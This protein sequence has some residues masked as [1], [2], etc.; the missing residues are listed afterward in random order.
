MCGRFT[1]EYTWQQVH[2]FLDLRWPD[3][4][5]FGPSYNV[6]PTQLSPIV[7]ADD[8]GRGARVARWGLQ[9]LWS[10]KPSSINARA[11]TV[12]TL[13][14]FRAA[15]QARRCVVP[16]SGF[17]EWQRVPV[18]Q[19]CYIRRADRCPM[20]LAGLW[21]PSNG[22]APPTFAIITTT[23]NQFMEAM[24][25]RMPAVLEP[26]CVERWLAE[27]AADL[28]R[29]A[30]EHILTAHRVSPQVNRPANDFYGLSEKFG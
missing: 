27:P 26:E 21:E 22:E 18:K 29:P 15:F 3:A 9:P 23:P 7:L 2:D 12:A 5:A 13:P 11:E 14:M 24:H 17:H 4:L 30:G 28:L 8:R 20:L 25:D 19:P 16:V 1:R 6:A 10:V